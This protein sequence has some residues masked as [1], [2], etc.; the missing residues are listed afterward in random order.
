MSFGFNNDDKL[1][2]SI[3]LRNLHIIKKAPFWEPFS[4][5]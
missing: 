1:A 5:Y 4:I 2:T 3:A